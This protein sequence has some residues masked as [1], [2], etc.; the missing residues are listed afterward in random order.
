M[1]DRPTAVQ[2]GQSEEW[3]QGPI[4]GSQTGTLS[5]E[6]GSD[7]LAA[8]PDR[9]AGEWGRWLDPSQIVYLQSWVGFL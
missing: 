3:E 9:Q 2:M 7:R 4:Q 8:M 5:L 1:L 6:I